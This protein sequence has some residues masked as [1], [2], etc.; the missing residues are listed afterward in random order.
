MSMNRCV[1][2]GRY[3]FLNKQA[4]HFDRSRKAST[5]FLT[6]A[7]E[8]TPDSRV[9]GHPGPYTQLDPSEVEDTA[10]NVAQ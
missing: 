2:R 7:Y 3:C 1:Q 8:K 6:I 10:D 5:H 4:E 9:R